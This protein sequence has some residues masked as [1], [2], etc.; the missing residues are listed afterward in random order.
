[1]KPILTRELYKQIKHYDKQQMEEFLQNLTARA[2][3]RGVSSI[4]QEMAKRIEA[5]IRKTKGIGEKRFQDLIDNIT[6]ELTKQSE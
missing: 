6:Q 4:N 3:N 1:M 5:G 2:Y